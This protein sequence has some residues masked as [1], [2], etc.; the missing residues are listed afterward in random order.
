[1]ASE[2]LLEIGTEEIPAGY[3]EHG[4]RGLKDLAQTCLRENRIG[5]AGE[6][7]TLGSPRRLVLVGKG[8]STMQEDLVK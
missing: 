7:V 3:L 8:V 6:L 4:L 1:M 5:L 2:L